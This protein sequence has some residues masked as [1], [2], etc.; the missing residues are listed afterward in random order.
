ML[1]AAASPTRLFAFWADDAGGAEQGLLA[2]LGTVQP[3]GRPYVR[4]MHCAYDQAT[5]TFEF[6]THA[7]AAKV[8]D[9][10]LN[11]HVSLQFFHAKNQRQVVV[12]G[13]AYLNTPEENV[14]QWAARPR[15]RNLAAWQARLPPK[16]EKVQQ[17]DDFEYPVVPFFCGF[18]VKPVA[19]D[20]SEKTSEGRRMSIHMEKSLYDNTWHV[21]QRL[22]LNRM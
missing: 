11:R 3:D 9:I 7:M 17:D 15:S 2:Q 10:K 16:D 18:V 22:I 21:K 12:A 8:Q 19:F 1:S 4:T 13:D 6:A 20:F 14:A 5:N